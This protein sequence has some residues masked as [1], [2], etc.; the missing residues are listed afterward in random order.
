MQSHSC[1][2]I[3]LSVSIV[4]TMGTLFS[5]RPKIRLNGLDFL[6]KRTVEGLPLIL[7]CFSCTFVHCIQGAVSSFSALYNKGVD[8]HWLHD[9]IIIHLSMIRV[10]SGLQCNLMHVSVSHC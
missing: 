10:R 7:P 6:L 4:G 5:R 2:S 9:L 3:Q 8:L 1:P